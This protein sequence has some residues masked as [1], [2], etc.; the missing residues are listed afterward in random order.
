MD[1]IIHKKDPELITK[2]KKSIENN[3][4]CIIKEFF[5]KKSICNKVE[6]LRETFSPDKDIRISGENYYKKENYQRLDLGFYGNSSY[7]RFSR[8]ITQFSWEKNSLFYNE[9]EELITFRNQV[10]NLY[11]NEDFTYN[12]NGEKLCDLPKVLHYPKGGGFM[13]EH[14]DGQ[15][16]W[17]WLINLTQRGKDYKKG[18]VFYR[19]STGE[20]IDA[21][22]ILEP[23][24]IY[25]HTLNALHGV[26]DIDNDQPVDIKTLDGRLVI[27]LSCERFKF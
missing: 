24:D 1:F 21:E 2:V 3:G 4:F 14:L 20:F 12:Y 16:I 19:T 9:V 11:R 5:D 26:N 25:T 15:V 22:E 18:G 7:A 13:V 27:N 10:L 8:M 17:N 23:G 6:E